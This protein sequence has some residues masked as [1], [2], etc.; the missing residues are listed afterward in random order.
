M[1]EPTWLRDDVIHVLH[2][3]L[4]AEF[5]G[6]GGVRD[7]GALEP[8]LARPLHRFAYKKSSLFDLAAEYAFGIVRNHPFT[9]G[10]KR[11]GFVAAITFL[12]LNGYRFTAS[13]ADATLRTLALASNEIGASEYAEWLK[14]NS[15]RG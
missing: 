6:A 7:A 1:K 14:T 3:Q 2:E 9:D 5:G 11:V 4:L 12:E 15:S 13:E 8:A 10:N